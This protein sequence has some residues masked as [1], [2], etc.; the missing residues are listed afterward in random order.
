[1]EAEPALW[2]ALGLGLFMAWGIGANDVANAMGTSVG[3]R[4]LRVG[5]A[6]LVA[7]VFEFLGAS[8]FGGN[9]TQTIRKGILDIEI[10]S[11]NP[12]TMV[13]GMLAS[14]AG[15]GTW[16]ALASRFGWPVSTTHSIVG[17]IVGFGAV[18]LGADAV[19]WGK[20]APIVTSWVVSPALSGTLA[21]FVFILIQRTILDHEAPAAQL[22]RYGP[23]YVL[24]VVVVIGLLTLFRGLKSV[25]FELSVAASLLLV[26]LLGV[27]VAGVAAYFIRRVPLDPS[28][29]R[30]FHFATVER[31]FAVLQIASACA[32]AF[33]H[34]SNDVA[35]AIG[36][37]AAIL[38]IL[39][40]GALEAQAPVPAW[41]LA[42]GGVGIVVGL[43]T[44]GYR[45]MATVGERITEL[46]PSRGYAAEFA[47]AVT[48]VLASRFG[49]PVSTTHTLVGAVLG[50]GLARG[51]G[52]L[53]YRVV[54]RIVASWVVTI[55]AGAVLS[56]FF[57]YFFKG[58]LTSI[59]GS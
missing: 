31:M 22:R 28:A 37:L 9:V 44:L 15:A 45:V 13:W 5:Q 11:A 41:I 38:S 59:G 42:L 52:A 2:L 53:D 25:D 30:A 49:I 32:V 24:A 34:G 14:L 36:P 48:I 43:S 50:V 4:A 7:A 21:F 20:L 56:I 39:G 17:A 18:A 33:A 10:A 6:I 51:I 8:L 46:T 55:P 40:T 1:M 3:S 27:A 47:T 58:L 23:L 35:N 12:T 29:D 54:G 26:G 19:E 57:Y 16:L